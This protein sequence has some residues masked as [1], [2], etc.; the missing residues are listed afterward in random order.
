[1]NGLIIQNSEFFTSNQVE[2]GCS[3]PGK[4]LLH[5]NPVITFA[6]HQKDAVKCFNGDVDINFS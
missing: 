1:M 2:K 6:L 5:P 4:K 3:R